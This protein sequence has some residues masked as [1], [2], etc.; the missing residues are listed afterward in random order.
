MLANESQLTSNKNLELD[1]SADLCGILCAYNIKHIYSVQRH[2]VS[3]SKLLSENRT[4]LK[5]G[6]NDL[7]SMLELSSQKTIEFDVVNSGKFTH[8]LY[9]FDFAQKVQREDSYSFNQFAAFSVIDQKLVVDSRIHS[10]IKINSFFKNSLL[11]LNF[12]QLIN[13][14]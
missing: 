13:M 14:C 3:D 9:W 11:H 4:I 10:K 12:N 7:D 8:I 6:F 5:I 2:D 1:E